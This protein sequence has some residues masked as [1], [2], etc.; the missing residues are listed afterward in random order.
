VK[1]IRI[2]LMLLWATVRIAGRRL[3]ANRRMAAG[4]LVGFVVAVAGAS[5]VPAFTAGALQ[6]MLQTDLKQVPDEPMPAAFHLAHFE[7]P[8][9][10]TTAAQFREADQIASKDGLRLIKLPV[11]PFVRYGA[12]DLTRAVP[13]DEMKV[14]PD[15][16]RWMAIAFLS[17]L[18][19]HINVIDGRWP[20]DGKQVDGDKVTYEAIVEEGALEKQDF[21][22]GAE[23]YV[24]VNRAEKSP[25]IRVHVVGVFHRKD[26]ADPYWFLAQSFDQDFFVTEPTFLTNVLD[27]PKMQPGQYSWYY[28]LANESIKMTD[29]VRLLTGVYELEAR[30][31]QVLP[32]TTL[33]EGPHEMLER[34]LLRARDL[35][36]MLLL[37]AVPPLAVVAYFLIVT[38]GMMVDGQRQE[39]AVLRSRGGSI[40]Q[41]LGIYLLE[42]SLLGALALVGGYPL[43]I[44]LARAMGAASGFL[45]F[46]DRKQPEL[47]LS[48]DFWLYGLLAAGLAVLAY[49][50]PV[51]AAAR[52]SIIS[53]KQ[54][55]ARKLAQPFWAKWFLDFVAVGLTAYAY[56]GLKGRQVATV[57]AGVKAGTELHLM[58]PLDVLAPALFVTGFGL[59][60]LRLV[61]LI[62]RLVARLSERRAGA[63]FYLT[64]NQ[65][66]RAAVSYTPVVLLLMLTVGMGLYSA[67]AARTLERNTIDRTLYAGGTDVVIDEVWNYIEEPDGHG[68]TQIKEV[69]PPPWNVQYD[70]PGVAHAARV[71]RQ[72]I[73]ATIGGKSSRKV[74]LLAIEPQDFG[75]VAWFRPDLAPYHLN[76]Y[77]N[78]LAQDEEAA[79]VSQ[80]Y[81]D[82]NKLRPGDRITLMSEQNAEV[83]LAVYGALPYWPSLYP[84]D[85]DFVIA[86]LET[87]ESSLS[88]LP[89]WSVWLKMEPDAK[90]QPVVDALR[91]KGIL[92]L[93]TTDTR[94]TLIKKRRDAQ[95]NGILGGL[96]SGFLV[97]ALVTVLGFW[98]YAALSL[99]S[100]VLQFGVLRAMGL[101]VRQL[102]GTVAL[103]QVLAVGI[104]VGAGTG[105]GLEAARLFVPFLQAGTEAA[106]RVP[107]F[108]IVNDPADRVRLYVVLLFMVV[109]G[110]AGLMSVLSRMRVH[111]A[112]K[113][114]EDV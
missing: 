63:S 114:G 74:T 31:A 18:Q 46:V 73:T 7:N 62:F 59:L 100:R 29:V 5:S 78:L 8:K 27:E 49:V 95:L 76:E 111:E 65:L 26:P 96:T 104:G 85:Q 94:Q 86:N 75:R 33:F 61:P 108:M 113:L 41:V 93:N 17:D 1:R 20:K 64:I 36:W 81:M 48:A 102:L 54:E 6:R 30:I 42:G 24:P 109:V 99:R 38:S 70:L 101:S 68:G 83:T 51:V 97:S 45:E 15:A 107:P 52:Q 2:A 106:S 58:Q 79:L 34:Y 39:I 71:R 3:N 66:S 84:Q 40:W 89:P 44:L 60:M 82:R 55:S 110:L 56:Y 50:V 23:F 53:Y 112:V 47:L 87:I 35:Q 103:E 80:S 19:P 22:L 88:M 69:Q 77:L 4:L 91:E 14:N 92:T 21:T 32:D 12:L 67:A 11:D 72:N 98:L 28:G 13:V 43:G 57:A 10:A 16:E 25:K 9:R 105:L 90:L 37:L